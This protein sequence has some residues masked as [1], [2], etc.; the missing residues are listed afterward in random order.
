MVGDIFT[1]AMCALL[2]LVTVL[3]AGCA[4][5]DPPE[6]PPMESAVLAREVPPLSWLAI[7]PPAGTGSMAAQLAV[8]GEETLATWLEP[9][10]EHDGKGGARHRLRFAILD[11]NRW[12]DARTVAS[13]DSFFVNWADFPAAARSRDGTIFAHWLQKSGEDTYA[14]DVFMARS[15]DGGKAW[16]PAGKL[17]D[18]S[19]AAEHGFV[20]FVEEGGGV[21]AFWLDGRDMGAGEGHDEGGHGAGSMGLR[22]ALIAETIG[23][24]TLLDP[25]TCECCQTAA[26]L[27]ARGPLVAYRDRSESEI[28]DIAI[29]RREGAGWS[30]PLRI[31]ED[32]WEV[33]GCPVNGPALAA[34]GDRV[35]VA[36]YTAPGNEGRVLAAFSESAGESWGSPVEIDGDAPMGRVDVDLLPEGDAVV[37]WIASSEEEG[38]IR[39]RRVSPDGSVGATFDLAR[40]LKSRAAGFPRTAVAGRRIVVAWTDAETPSHVHSAWLDAP[41]LPPVTERNGSRASIPGDAAEP[42]SHLPSLSVTDLGGSHRDLGDLTGRPLLLNLWATWCAPCRAEMPD[43]ARLH[44]EFAARGLRV[45]GL[46]LDAPGAAEDIR[47]FVEKEAIPY[48]ILHDTSGKAATLFGAATLPAS[49]LYDSEGKLSWERH[50][51]LTASDPSLREALE[52]SLS[53]DTSR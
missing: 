9:E 48:D 29:V 3:S 16:E 31:H 4:P 23:P 25:R 20:S 27:T 39:V 2:V 49:F 47:R 33:P 41:R 17:N 18:D 14:Y 24:S 32:G 1:R 8:A 21:R 44:E 38:V 10:P 52:A 19:V 42:G 50:G 34:S 35:A 30:E 6:P 40:T 12:S 7:D 5:G 53:L 36:W 28:R 11:G 37:T 45:V 22:T 13:G 15:R 26:A 51:P 46:S 43:L